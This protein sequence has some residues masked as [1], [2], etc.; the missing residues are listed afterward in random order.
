[1]NVLADARLLP[2]AN[3]EDFAL[4][5]ESLTDVN[6]NGKGNLDHKLIC[7]AAPSL[8]RPSQPAA[9]MLGPR[10]LGSAQN[11]SPQNPMQF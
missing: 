11:P 5:P 6:G 2:V 3:L 7:G 1:M 10:R 8:A 4:Q 9:G